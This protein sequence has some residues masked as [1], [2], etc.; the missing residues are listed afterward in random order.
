MPKRQVFTHQINVRLDA[1]TYNRVM[2]ATEKLGL[3]VSEYVRG[4]VES[5]LSRLENRADRVPD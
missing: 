1:D 5:N 2:D 3:P 4:L